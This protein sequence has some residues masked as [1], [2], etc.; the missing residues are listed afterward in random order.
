MACFHGHLGDE[1][2]GSTVVAVDVIRAATTAVTA[3]ATGRRLFPV[4]SIEAAVPLAA[5]LDDP[6]LAGEL[7]GTMPYGFHLQNSPYEVERLGDPSRPM[8]LL[9]TSGTR[10]MCEAAMR[11]D[12][13]VGCLRNA[14]ALARHLSDHESVLVLGADSRGEFRDEDQLCCARIARDLIAAGFEPRDSLTEEVVEQWG[15]A[16]EEAILGGHS[17][18]YLTST[19]QQHDLDFVLEH[20]DDL[21]AVFEVLGGEVRMAPA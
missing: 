15:E 3:V 19:G 8:I 5:R 7:G 4:P 11:G 9:S 2:Q 18:E 12:V 10:L 13:F 6:F 21:D 1:A 20:V 14:R 16:P 17:A